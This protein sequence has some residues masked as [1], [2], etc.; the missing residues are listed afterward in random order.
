[1]PVHSVNKLRNTNWGKTAIKIIVQKG[2]EELD[3][4]LCILSKCSVFYLKNGL[5][6]WP[7]DK[8]DGERK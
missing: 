5:Q 3:S 8:N 6:F 2:N 1:M 4:V 7:S